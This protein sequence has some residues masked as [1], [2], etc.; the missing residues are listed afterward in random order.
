MC[1][2]VFF[3]LLLLRHHR[4]HC[5]FRKSPQHSLCGGVYIVVAVNQAAF[6]QCGTSFT[7]F[8]LFFSVHYS[9]V[10]SANLRSANFVRLK[11]VSFCVRVSVCLPLLALCIVGN[12]FCVLFLTHT[13]NRCFA[14]S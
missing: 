12:V 6:T 8:S 14:L 11:L 3:F 2:C 7:S 4:Q 1:H 10:L 13:G 5:P 9:L